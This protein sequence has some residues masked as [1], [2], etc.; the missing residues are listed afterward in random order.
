MVYLLSNIDLELSE[1]GDEEV[2]TDLDNQVG[3]EE[4]ETSQNQVTSELPKFDTDK[5]PQII[6]KPRCSFMSICFRRDKKYN[7]PFHSK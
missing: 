2:K 4:T 1:D 3:T 5:L 6:S 7:D